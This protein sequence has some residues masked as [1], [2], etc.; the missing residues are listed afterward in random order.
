VRPARKRVVRWKLTISAVSGGKGSIWVDK[1]PVCGTR[2]GRRPYGLQPKVEPSTS[3]AHEPARISVELAT[4][5][6]GWLVAFWWSK[7]NG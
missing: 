2:T 3:L 4:P 5:R 7:A 1:S 6:S